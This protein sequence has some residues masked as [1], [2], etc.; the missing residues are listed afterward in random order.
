MYMFTVSFTLFLVVVR[1]S[2]FAWVLDVYDNLT[3]MLHVLTTTQGRSRTSLSLQLDL[4]FG[5][6][7]LA[8]A[9]LISRW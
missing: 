4:F 9:L 2:L 5:V 6:V 1:L 7:M 3:G 8:L